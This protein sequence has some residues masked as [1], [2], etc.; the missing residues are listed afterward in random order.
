MKKKT[1]ESIKSKYLLMFVMAVCV[2]LIFLTFTTDLESGPLKQVAQTVITPVQNG[3]NRVGSWILDKG[4]YFQDS[5]TIYEEN[6]ILKE[7]VSEL[8]AEN[9]Q[10]LQNQDELERLRDLYDLD[11]QYQDY[12]KIGARIIAKGSGNWFNLFTINKGSDDGIQVDNNVIADGGLV[13]IVTEVGKNWATVRA[14]CDDYS[15]V[16]AMVSTTSD[17]CIVS[18][19]LTLLD[20]GKLEMSKLIDSENKVSVG[21]KVVTSHVSEKYLPGILIGYISDISSDSNQ[22]TKSGYITPVVDFKHLQE[23]LVI[24]KLKETGNS[25]LEETQ[26]ETATPDETAGSESEGTEE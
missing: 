7:K 4:V 9:T 23:V 25:Q 10:L 18:G 15:N 1:N 8:T 24:T 2:V 3:F 16:S 6:Q 21:A 19:N 14:I 13:G 5:A 12:P 17:I 11:R 26:N 22:L 20:E